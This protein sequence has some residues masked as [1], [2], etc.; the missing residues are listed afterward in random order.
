MKPFPSQI[1][2]GELY[3]PAMRI[4]NQGEADEYFERLVA[5][6]MEHGLTRETAEARER[7]NIAYY[8]AYGFDRQRIEHLFKCAHPIFG[9]AEI[10][11]EVLARPLA[12]LNALH[13]GMRTA[14]IEPRT[15]TNPR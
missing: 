7:E 8:A 5:R 15:S 14:G 10:A 13:A 9:T 2:I 4:T 3:G 11:A 6:A 12:G 1:T